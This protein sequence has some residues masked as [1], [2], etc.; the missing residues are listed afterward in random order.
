MFHPQLQK[1]EN[2]RRTL[3]ILVFVVRRAGKLRCLHE[4]DGYVL[5]AN[6]ICLIVGAH[7]K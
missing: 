4:V 3:P 7:G 2:I 6:A 5:E 1:I